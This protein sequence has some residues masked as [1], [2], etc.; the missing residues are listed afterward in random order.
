LKIFWDFAGLGKVIRNN[1]RR[2]V[3]VPSAAD[4]WVVDIRLT[5]VKSKPRPT[6]P[7]HV[8]CFT[9]STGFSDFGKK[10][11]WDSSKWGFTA[12]KSTIKSKSNLYYKW[13]P[14]CLGVRHPLGAR[15][16]FLFF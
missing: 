2:S 16:Q 12:E 15:S 9:V 6:S 8:F 5:A 11:K 13:P 7:S 10:V 14:V 3:V 4:R 1:D